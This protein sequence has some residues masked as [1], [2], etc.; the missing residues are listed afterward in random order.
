[1]IEPSIVAL[2]VHAGAARWLIPPPL[3]FA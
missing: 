1:M 3:P 2:P